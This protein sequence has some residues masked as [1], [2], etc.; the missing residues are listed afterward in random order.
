MRYS[1]YYT[2]TSI[3]LKL[4]I[5]AIDVFV[6]FMFLLAKSI[7]AYLQY[8]YSKNESS[9]NHPDDNAMIHYKSFGFTL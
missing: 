9:H 3:L 6:S 7:L 5:A 1:V 2:K 8:K 4:A